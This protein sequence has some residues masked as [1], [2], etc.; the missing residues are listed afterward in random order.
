[1]WR[2]R[3]LGNV[4]AERTLKLERP[5]RRVTA[6]RVKFGQ[7][8]RAPKPGR[9]DPWWCP[10]VISGLGNRRL[11]RVAGEDSLQALILALEFVARVLSL[12]AGLAG[13]RI[14]WLGERESLVFANT[15]TS[16]LLTRSLQNC[17]TALADAVDVLENPGTGAA[18]RTMARRLRALIAS[19]GYTANPREA[20]RINGI[21]SS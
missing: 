14:Q 21:S 20:V 15:L 1:M 9:G 2:P 16:S 12:E 8:V 18:V 4:I 6:I 11:E 3:T 7:P 10:V 17:I 13:A 5:G 19:S